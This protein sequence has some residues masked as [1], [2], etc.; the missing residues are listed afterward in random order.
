M[1]KGQCQE[2]QAENSQR[3][4]EIHRT[5]DSRCELGAQSGKQ[6]GQRCR[7][8]GH[9]WR[10]QRTG[11]GRVREQT[12]EGEVKEVI[13]SCTEN[14]RNPGLFSRGRGRASGELRACKGRGALGSGVGRADLPACGYKEPAGSNHQRCTRK[15][16][17]GGRKELRKEEDVMFNQCPRQQQCSRVGHLFHVYTVFSCLTIYPMHILTFND[18]I[19]C[20]FDYIINI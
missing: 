5:E 18:I 14:G 6:R 10:L 3:K 12:G 19:T 17:D 9:H 7:H 20:S 8:G 15:G 16:Q 13:L 11:S 4:K 2:K 1:R